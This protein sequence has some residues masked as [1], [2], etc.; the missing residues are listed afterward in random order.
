MATC[1]GHGEIRHERQAQ[2]SA[3]ALAQ[4]WCYGVG[5][6]KCSHETDFRS[7]LSSSPALTT[8][9]QGPSP[10]DIDPARALGRLPDGGRPVKLGR[11]APPPVGWDVTSD[12]RNHK[13]FSHSFQTSLLA[14][15]SAR[16]EQCKPP[17]RVGLARTKLLFPRLLG[18][19]IW[20]RKHPL[21]TPIRTPFRPSLYHLRSLH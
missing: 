10:T 11:S 7:R 2:F 4:R 18:L 12:R 15:S 13:Q 8:G 21:P 1:S 17:P 9:M 14:S 19:Y 6:A 5:R 20:T 16:V 3:L